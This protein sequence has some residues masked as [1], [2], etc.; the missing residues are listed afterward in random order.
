MNLRPRHIFIK[1]TTTVL[2]VFGAANVVLAQAGALGSDVESLLEFAKKRNPEYAALRLESDAAIERIIPAGALPD[3]KLRTE[4][5]DVTRSGEQSPTFYPSRVGSMR[6]QLTQDIPWFGKR[7]I[8]REIAKLE[9]GSAKNLAMNSWVEISSRVK[10]NF[11][12]LYY[13]NRN[14]RLSKEILEL[15]VRLEKIAQVRYANGLVHQ[16]DVIRAQVEQTNVKSEI[17]ALENELRKAQARL[18]A[19]LLRSANAPLEEPVQLRIIPLPEK[20]EYAVLEKQALARNPM[21]LTEELR[22]QAAEKKRDLVYKNR[23]P[24]FKF[25]I[26]PV[27]VGHSIKE[28]GVMVELNIPLQQSSR[29]SQERESE[30]RLS[31]ARMRK[32]STSSQVLAELAENISG[33]KAAQKIE[34]LTKNNLLP[35]TSLTFNAALAGYENGK[36]DFATLLDAQKQIRKARQTLI[37]AQAEGQIRLAAIERLL[38][39]DI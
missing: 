36:L 39:M 28:W 14:V 35:Q 5:R 29:R 1:I 15:V 21:I 32:A 27:Q 6:Y 7:D 12:Q 3:P 4:F 8:K 34:A 17:V 22:L 18:N 19:L 13:L 23:Y 10:S 38:G 25:G 9:A 37:K 20:L 24:D 31:A 26:S 2:L 30:A 11:A 16:Q 33:L